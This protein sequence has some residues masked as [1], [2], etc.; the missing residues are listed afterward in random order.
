MRHL[1]AAIMVVVLFI[2]SGPTAAVDKSGKEFIMACTYGVLAGTLV[3]AA[4]LAFTSQPGQNLQLVAR[5]AS[6][7]LY[8]GILLGVYV[9][10]IVPS[11]ETP[12]DDNAPLPT[13]REPKFDIM[14]T[15]SPKGMD[16]M[17]AQ[18]RL[19]SF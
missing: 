11:L 9:V 8:A 12:E 14:P 4:S 10:Y 7:G 16:G 19:M 18:F 3:G 5:G 17:Q 1:G 2:Y 6:L 15:M 13:M